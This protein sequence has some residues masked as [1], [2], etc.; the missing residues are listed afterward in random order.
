MMALVPGM[1]PGPWRICMEPPRPPQKPFFRPMISAIDALDHPL[2]LGREILG[3]RVVARGRRG[4][5]ELRQHLMMSAVGAVDLVAPAQDRHG[6]HGTRLLADGGM[7]RPMDQAETV[8]LQDL[9]LE[10][11]DEQHLL[12]PALEIFRVLGRPVGVLEVEPEPG[13]IRGD[14][15]RGRH[16][17]GPDPGPHPKRSATTAMA[18]SVAS[19]ARSISASLWAQERNMVWTGWR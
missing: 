8:K 2:H 13:R 4:A 1:P 3:E 17:S 12:H 9:L 5:E 10:A 18:A 16:G 6:A 7:G 11:P 15:L 19:S 14:L